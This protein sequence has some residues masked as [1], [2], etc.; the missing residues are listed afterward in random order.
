MAQ[1]FIVCAVSVSALALM[2]SRADD[3]KENVH[4]RDRIAMLNDQLCVLHEG[5]DQDKSS[6]LGHLQTRMKGLDQSLAESQDRQERRFNALQEQLRQSQVDLDKERTFR[7]DLTESKVEELKRIDDWLDA[8]LETQN[9][10]T[11]CS[12]DR[13]LQEFKTKTKVIK[14][15]MAV[16]ERER[17][18]TDNGFLEH[19]EQD[20]PQ[21]FTTLQDE[22]MLREEMEQRLLRQAMEEIT[23]LQA[24]VLE[25][26]REREESEEVMIQMMERIVVMCKTEIAEEKADRARSEDN[27]MRMLAQTTGQL[28]D[29]LQKVKTP[30]P[31]ESG[32][33]MRSGS[34]SVRFP[35]PGG[36]SS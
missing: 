13:I 25:E 23:V 11:V 20:I 26:K 14:E 36:L 34:P 16:I 28:Q 3:K 30:Q 21:L 1:F 27:F 10:A 15:E 22:V 7:E 19:L 17:T 9:E 35:S 2:V 18:E 6:R 24:A 8:S 33:G 12:R 4:I 5:L 32:S 31:G 29:S